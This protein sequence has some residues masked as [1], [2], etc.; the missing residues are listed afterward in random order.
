MLSDFHPVLCHP[1]CYNAG[2][3]DYIVINLDQIGKVNEWAEH[4]GAVQE[5]GRLILVSIR[6]RSEGCEA[7]RTCVYKET[8]NEAREN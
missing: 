8:E 5:F 6:R 3:I 4:H 7:A 2:S 1:R